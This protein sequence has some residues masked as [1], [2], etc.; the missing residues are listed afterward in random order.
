M[1][2]YEPNEE[3]LD[4]KVT[5]KT[6][7][8]NWNQRIYSVKNIKPISHESMMIT[9]WK[10][11]FANLE[12]IQICEI[13]VLKNSYL[14]HY[15]ILLKCKDKFEVI[16]EQLSIKKKLELKVFGY[17]RHVN[18]TVKLSDNIPIDV[19]NII[20]EY[21][22][23]TFEQATE[24]I[25]YLINDNQIRLSGDKSKLEL[26]AYYKQATVGKCSE[27]GDPQPRSAFQVEKKARWDAWN[28][29]A[30]VSTNEAKNICINKV[31]S[32]PPTSSLYEYLLIHCLETGAKKNIHKTKLDLFATNCLND[33][34]DRLAKVLRLKVDKVFTAIP[35]SIIP[36][37]MSIR[38]WC[39]GFAHVVN[40]RF[41]QYQSS[42]TKIDM[43]S[44]NYKQK[45]N[46]ILAS[47]FFFG[48][49]IGANPKEFTERWIQLNRGIILRLSGVNIEDVI[50]G[51]GCESGWSFWTTI[52]KK[53]I[54]NDGIYMLQR[55]N[56]GRWREAAL[57]SRSFV[58]WSIHD[59]HY[60]IVYQ[61]NA[62]KEN[63]KW[64]SVKSWQ[65]WGQSWVSGQEWNEWGRGLKNFQLSRRWW[66]DIG[67]GNN[68]GEMKRIFQQLTSVEFKQM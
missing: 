47:K 43:I 26:Y 4:C 51:L 63:S 54:D 17:I 59:A 31:L 61:S 3:E 25:K 27:K 34:H 41:A 10:L 29:I 49:F 11:C 16:D 36:N 67:R 13:G 64:L 55:H 2:A 56:E 20:V 39:N 1:T 38:K 6:T 62:R 21:V 12:T 5:T 46:C 42:K 58:A 14:P 40:S 23:V 18:N 22:S 15:G 57:F 30:D 45:V 28:S 68:L 60:R 33:A 53:T 32:E 52:Q 35:W 44:Q 48:L 7:T 65:N 19:I 24:Y 9:K 50:G 37:E 66:R 8:H